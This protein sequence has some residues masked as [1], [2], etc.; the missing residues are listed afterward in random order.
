[1]YEFESIEETREFEEYEAM[2]TMPIDPYEEQWCREFDG[3][4]DEMQEWHDFDPD[5]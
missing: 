1:M 2:E 5:C 4:P 3:Q